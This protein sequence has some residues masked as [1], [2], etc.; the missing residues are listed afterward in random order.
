[1]V[2]PLP[3]H[4]PFGHD[5]AIFGY[6]SLVSYFEESGISQVVF[7]NFDGADLNSVV[8]ELLDALELL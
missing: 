8:L 5:G 6:L 2:F 4:A 3:G 1:M 7:L